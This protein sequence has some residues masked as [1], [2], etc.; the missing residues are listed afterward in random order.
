M[1]PDDPRVDD[2]RQQLKALG[3]LDAGVDRFLLAPARG[4]RGPIALAARASVRVGLLGGALLGPAA[5]I[6]LGARLPGLVS[7]VRDA[8]VLALYLGVLFFLAV[9]VMSFLVSALAAAFGRTRDARF[10]ARAR[11]LSVDAGWVITAGCLVYLTFWWR[12]ANAGFG[13]S[14]PV[15]TAFAL[16]VAVGISLLLGHAVRITTLAVL[17][18]GGRA[19]GLPP[20]PGMSW[21]VLVGGGAL[22]FAGA[23]FLLVLTAADRP[24]AADHPPLTVVSQGISV[25]LIAIDGF[26][27]A[28]YDS[29]RERAPAAADLFGARFPLDPQDTADPARA[30]TTIATG[31]PPD[32]HGVN[33]LETTRLAGVQGIVAAGSG[34]LA[35]TIRAA[36]DVVRLTRPSIASRDERRS[37]TV[38]EVAEEAGLRTAVVNW[39][40]TWPAPP[41]AG[42]VITDRAVLRLEHGGALDGEIS[43]ADVYPQL[44]RQWPEIRTRAVAAA[45]A[46]FT[47]VTDAGALSVLRRSAELDG[48]ILGIA[49]ALPGPSRDLDVV[50]LPGLDIAQHALLGAP[51]GNAPAPSAVAA[52]VDA[53]R[54]YYGFLARSLAS[55]VLPSRKQI[56]MV[57]TQ[58]GRIQSAVPGVLAI[59]Q[60]GVSIDLTPRATRVVDVMPTVLYALG[61]PLS[62][63]LAGE[64]IRELFGGAD[65]N[66]SRERYVSTYGRPFTR[67]VS[68]EGRPLDQEMIDRL[69]SLGY[70]K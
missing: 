11:V 10:A 33:G 59:R 58:P 37:K 22:A 51:D 3:Y 12:N 69:R 56:V 53:L 41:G 16:A 29:I 8:C 46:A 5:A 65:L 24:A 64:P 54:S 23:A 32:V 38:W 21:R 14:A 4:T 42:L 13:W 63:E 55:S 9:T 25:R 35:R 62:R 2:L 57:V 39:W 30:W 44:Q 45:A 49:Q 52:R 50:Y 61:V 15:W 66:A 47:E 20:V 17:A 7:G 67:P 60:D 70:V 40:A 19:A 34:P 36:T 27:P 68:R 26:D 6:G 43:P 18:S 1:S 48:T 31:E 28:I